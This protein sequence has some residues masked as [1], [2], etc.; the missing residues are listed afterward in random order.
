M[1]LIYGVAG[2]LL[3][4]G[5]FLEFY[6]NLNV[7]L[8]FWLTAAQ[9]D[10]VGI[11]TV[12]F[13]A[14]SPA[15]SYSLK[16]LEAIIVDVRY[17]NVVDKEGLTL[18]PPTLWDF[19]QTFRSDLSGAGLNLPILPGV[20]A[21]P[22]TIFL[23]L[24]NNKNE[25]KD[26]AGRP[27]S[28]GY[29]LE[30]TTSGVTITGASPLGA[31]WGTR[32]VLQQV[33]VSNFKIPVG[34]GIDTPGWGE[35]GM[36]LDVGRHYYPLDFIIEMCAYLS[37]FK[38]NV[39]HLHLNDH[40]WDPAKLGSHELALQLYAAF[41]PSSD[42]PSIAGLPCPTNKTYSLSVMDNIQQQCTARGVTII[43]E[44][45]S[46][47]HSMATTNWKPELALS[48]FNMLNISYPE[49]IPT[50][51]NYWKALLLGFHSKIVHIGADEHASN[52]VDEY[53]YFVNTIASYIKEILGKSTC[54]WGTFALSTE[55][56]VTNVNTSVLIQQW[57]ISQDN[58]YFDF[59]KKGYQVL[60]SDDFFY[61]D[62][63][64]S[65]GGYPPAVDLQ[66]VFFG[67]LD[68]GPYAPNIF[69]HSNATNNPA[70][71]D[72]SVLGQL[73]VVWNDWGP[74]ASTCNEAYWM[75]RDG[76]LALGDK[77]WGGKLTLPEYESV[78]PKLQATVP[79]QNLDRRIASKTSTILHYTFDEGILELL[80]IVPDVS[81]NK[82]NGALHGGAKV[83]N[84]ML[85]L[86]GNGYLQTPLGSKGRNY[87]LSF[88]VM[89]T[90][91]ALGGVLFSG[92]DS[93][94]LNGNGTSSKLMLVSGNIAYPVDLTLAKNKWTDVTVQGI[95][96]QTFISIT[97]QGS[98]KQTQEV[99]INMGIWGGGMLEGPMA[100]EAPIQKIGEG[101][102]F[103]MASQASDIVLLT[104]GNGHVG[105]HMIEQ[106]LALPTS[107]IIRTT[108]RS[109]RAVSQLEQK[110]GDA[111]A[112]GKLNAVIVAD[113]TTPNAFDDVLNRVT[114]VAHVASPL[115][116][117]ATD[118]ENELLI[119][120]IQGTVGLLK[121]ASKIKSVKSVVITSSFAA[122]FDPAKGWRKGY[123][124]TLSDWNPI[125]YETAKDPSLDLTRWPETWRPYITYIASKKLAEKAAW[126]FWNTEK[127]QWDLN[128]VLP[129][130]IIGPYLLPISMLDGMSYSNKLVWE[131]ALAEKLP[132]LNYPHWVDVRDVAKAHIQV[133]QHPV[134][135]SQRY[136]L[137]PTRLTYSEMA[138]IVR[139]KFPSLKP[140]EEKQT[141][142]YY[143][144]DISN[145]EDIGMDSWIPIEKSVED[146]VSQ[147]LEVKS[148]SG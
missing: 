46:S 79:G 72:P 108:V 127:P 90:S 97:A 70:H 54:I 95:G 67:A 141:V 88:S 123:T 140:S 144:I 128:F 106:L 44:L 47:G 114:H 60:N 7:F 131:V 85:Y 40:V 13:Q 82:Y 35:R 129:T 4:I 1:R 5:P 103:N 30:V 121:S 111:I 51:Q 116:I 86:N 22:H 83:R 16:S 124:Y 10:L 73:C 23:T 92:P 115:I 75:V 104:G 101:F 139:K 126:D 3:A 98:S 74:N 9:A 80:P 11:P 15:K 49:T 6:A 26:V 21:T 57:E 65:E 135:R 143:D 56:G 68:G 8:F 119:P 55:L 118:I 63:K 39:F 133:L 28:E 59:I 37:F 62:L 134:I 148:R 12:P 53:T 142:E 89:P 138:D 94:F 48:D 99:T 132:N 91:S 84:G 102:F 33:I 25:F 17:S 18:I 122:V 130:Y 19:A 45:E 147:I 81:G 61:L 31:W 110:F 41:R 137:A 112:N 34:K 96:A 43:P 2:A 52:F 145:C 125:T 20:I 42:D 71:N 120:T 66:R 50:V 14:S 36:M 78:F 58:G 93:S 146:L 87:T 64:H 100:I 27:T 113:I 109:G 24:G 136:I 29:S 32:T 38:Q 76:L 105:Q 69:D 117:G 77:Q 107:P